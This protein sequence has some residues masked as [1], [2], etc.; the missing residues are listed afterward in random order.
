MQLTEVSVGVSPRSRCAVSR[1]LSRSTA[2]LITPLLRMS[3]ACDRCLIFK[4]KNARNISQEVCDG[5][6]G[7]LMRA[8]LVRG[9]AAPPPH[10]GGWGVAEWARRLPFSICG[11][12]AAAVRHLWPA[13]CWRARGM[14]CPCALR[15]CGLWV[16]ARAWPVRLWVTRRAFGAPAACCGCCCGCG[17]G[18][19]RCAWR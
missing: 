12:C 16:V 9:C 19:A 8:R 5:D 18:R 7:W 1:D 13:G 4:D 3:Y 10:R 15:R 14:D 2:M 17:V 11:G 6:S